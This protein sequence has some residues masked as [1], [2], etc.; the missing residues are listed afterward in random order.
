MSFLC[1]GIIWYRG[2]YYILELKTESI[3]KWQSRQ[4]VDPAHYNQAIAYSAALGLDEVIFIYINR[5]LLDM[6]AFLFTVTDDMKQELVGKIEECD[7][8]VKKRT[9]PP[10]PTNIDRK[11]CEYCQ[12]KKACRRDGS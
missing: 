12:Y 7:S 4:G 11:T 3:Y 1:D 8:Y 9:T 6:K 10:K 2:H 5:D